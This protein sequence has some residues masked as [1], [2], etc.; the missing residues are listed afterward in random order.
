M[1]LSAS[2]G[3]GQREVRMLHTLL[4]SHV[5]V[6]VRSGLSRAWRNPV[7]IKL[8]PLVEFAAAALLLAE[9]SFLKIQQRGLLLLL[10]AAGTTESLNN[11]CL[12]LA[13]FL[14]QCVSSSLLVHFP[15]PTVTLLACY[16]SA[17][18]GQWLVL[19]AIQAKNKCWGL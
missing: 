15:C 18:T 17:L 10:W 11:R 1:K 13:V 19:T 12:C 8:K 2:E 16:L 7:V 5:L 6:L 3:C 9:S 14:L 4:Q